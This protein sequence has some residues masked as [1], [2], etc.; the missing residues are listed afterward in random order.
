[1]LVTDVTMLYE[2]RYSTVKADMKDTSQ[3]FVEDRVTFV[4]SR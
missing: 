1:M 2:T 4:M 3:E